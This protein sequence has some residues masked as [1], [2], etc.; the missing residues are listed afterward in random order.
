M[1]Q[2]VGKTHVCLERN[3]RALQGKCTTNCCLA[4]LHV[5]GKP[6]VRCPLNAADLHRTRPTR[7]AGGTCYLPLCSVA[8]SALF[9]FYVHRCWPGAY[10]TLGCNLVAL[11]MTRNFIFFPWELTRS[12]VTSEGFRSLLAFFSIVGTKL[13]RFGSNHSSNETQKTRITAIKRPWENATLLSVQV[14]K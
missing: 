12:M 4:T 8:R 11:S 3:C 1:Q 5:R 13:P 10:H 6:S 14:S 2:A 9:F 7:A